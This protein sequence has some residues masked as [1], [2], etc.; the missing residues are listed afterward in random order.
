MKRIVMT[1]SFNITVEVDPALAEGMRG[2]LLA[3][4][5]R[6]VRVSSCYRG[7]RVDGLPG[8]SRFGVPVFAAC[9]DAVMRLHELAD[10]QAEF[11]VRVGVESTATGRFML[12]RAAFLRCVAA[13]LLQ[14]RA[15]LWPTESPV[16][17]AV[18]FGDR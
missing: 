9:S 16:D 3:K 10:I 1:H 8:M 5:A 2:D 17:V 13:E 12:D 18:V 14:R 6:G 15:Q 4:L 11:A 7:V